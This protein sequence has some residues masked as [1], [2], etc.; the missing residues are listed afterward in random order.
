MEKSKNNA[1]RQEFCMEFGLIL[2]ID[3]NTS[4]NHSVDGGI[5]INTVETYRRKLIKKNEMKKM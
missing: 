1:I 2:I 4:H 3:L 5:G